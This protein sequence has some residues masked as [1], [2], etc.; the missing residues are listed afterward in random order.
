M[1]THSERCAYRA[2]VNGVPYKDNP[3]NLPYDNEGKLKQPTTLAER[4]KLINSKLND[5]MSE[6]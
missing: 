4:R 6:G 5:V 3:F 2:K 1:K